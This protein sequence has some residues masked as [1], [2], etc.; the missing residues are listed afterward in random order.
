M[1]DAQLAF[2]TQHST[3]WQQHLG[4]K[5]PNMRCGGWLGGDLEREGRGGR[6]KERAEELLGLC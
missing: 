1:T 5:Q 3:T 4:Y 2:A 6:E